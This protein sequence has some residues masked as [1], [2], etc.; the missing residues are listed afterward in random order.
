[1]TRPVLDADPPAAALAWVETATGSPV[2]GWD[3][4][5]GATT[6]AVHLVRLADGSD[7][8]LKHFIWA[9]FLDGHPE[10]A[11]R[12]AWA[13]AAVNAHVPA[14]DLLAVDPAGEAAGAPAV[15]MSYLPGEPDA[16][17]DPVRLAEVAAAIA[18]VEPSACPWS[19]RPYFDGHPLFAPAW[20]SDR[21]AWEALID[22]VDGVDRSPT[23]FIH[24]DFHPWNV[25]SVG[26]EV[27]GVVDWLSA[28]AGPWQIDVSHCR[29]NLVLL[30]RAESADLYVA[31]YERLT[32]RSYGPEWDALNILDALPFYDGEKA[33]SRWDGYSATGATTAPR[34]EQRLRLDAFAGRTVQALA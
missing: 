2:V 8:V 26:S 31:E 11:A 16:A 23:G 14:P 27:T 4:L 5:P 22:I 12:E 20:S 29:L 32:G 17:L 28:G 18:T 30:G 1:M 3:A 19:Y 6:A 21:A 9:D 25:L 24:R 7:V 34:T 10:A 15:L 13:L 33:V